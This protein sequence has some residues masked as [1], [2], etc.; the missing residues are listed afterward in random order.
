MIGHLMTSSPIQPVTL[1]PFLP[2][3]AEGMKKFIT[4]YP[5]LPYGLGDFETFTQ[6]WISDHSCVLDLW[7]G[8]Q[9]VAVAVLLD[10]FEAQPQS[11]EVAVLGYRWDFSAALFLETVIP[12]AQNK[13]REQKKLKIEMISSLGLKVAPADLNRKGFSTGVTV[14]TYESSPTNPQ[15][16]VPLPAKWLWQEATEKTVPLCYELLKLNFP[17]PDAQSLV[18]YA[19]FERLALQLPIKPHLLFEDQTAI[20]FVWVAADPITGQLLFIARHPRYRGQGLGKVCLSEAVR[21]LQPVGIKR[22]QA[23]VKDS[24]RSAIRLFEVSGFRTVRK[25]TRFILPL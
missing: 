10:R 14:I 25:L 7:Q 13:A 5:R 4:Q 12:A 21:L 6:Q 22:L 9:R 15:L 11:V 20:A 18:P 17:E 24:D 2:S 1:K 3:N 23:E 8:N 19:Q 16:L